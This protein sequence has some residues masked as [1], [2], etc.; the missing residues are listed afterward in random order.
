MK[1]IKLFPVT[2][3]TGYLRVITDPEVDQKGEA[4]SDLCSN[5]S[6]I[7]DGGKRISPGAQEHD[8]GFTENTKICHWPG[9]KYALIANPEAPARN[10]GA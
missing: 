6:A 10:T 1:A 7:G 9:G 2:V 3:W 8:A 5:K 4:T